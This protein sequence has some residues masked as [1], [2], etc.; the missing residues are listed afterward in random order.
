MVSQQLM[1]SPKE[2]GSLDWHQETDWWMTKEI[3]QVMKTMITIGR[4]TIRR[5]REFL[6]LTMTQVPKHTK[7]N[8]FRQGPKEM[9][10]IEVFLTPT[11]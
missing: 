2:G 4:I 3:L 10:L 8:N 6:Q 9:S 5:L 7:L 1:A 11:L